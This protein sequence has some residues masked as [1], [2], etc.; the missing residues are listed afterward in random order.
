MS[1]FSS[2]E[3]YYSAGTSRE[4]LLE[5]YPDPYKAAVVQAILSGGSISKHLAAASKASLGAT[6]GVYLRYGESTFTNELPTGSS[7][8][9]ELN[10]AALLQVV[11]EATGGNPVTINFQ[12][13][14]IA[15]ERSFV[16]EYMQQRY[17]FN[18]ETGV[19]TRNPLGLVPLTDAPVLFVGIESLGEELR[20]E[21][22]YD[23]TSSYFEVIDDV[24]SGYAY[25][26]EYTIDSEV[27]GI[28]Q[29]KVEAAASITAITEEVSELR[30]DLLGVSFTT[31]DITTDAIFLSLI[32]DARDLGT[33]STSDFL[34]LYETINESRPF[35]DQASVGSAAEDGYYY[36][37]T[38]NNIDDATAAANDISGDI[39]QEYLWNY[40][41]EDG[42]YPTLAY[43]STFDTESRYL[44]IVPI[45][46]DGKFLSTTPE[47]PVYITGNNL[48]KKI[49]LSHTTFEEAIADNADIEDF[50]QVFY[51]FTV[52]MRATSGESVKYLYELWDREAVINGIK[53]DDSDTKLSTSETPNT[54]T[55][56]KSIKKVLT[57]HEH[58]YNTTITFTGINKENNPSGN[59]G[60]IGDVVSSISGDS[61]RLEKQ[62]TETSTEVVTVYGVS[63]KTLVTGRRNLNVNATFSNDEAFY[64]PINYDLVKALPSGAQSLILAESM[65]IIIYWL[66]REVVK[67]GFFQSTFFKV[68]LAVITIIIIVSTG[69]D[70]SAAFS[71]LLETTA[72]E[73][74]TEIAIYYATDYALSKLAEQGGIF[75]VIA[76]VYLAYTFEIG[77]FGDAAKAGNMPLAEQLM[78]AV[79]AISNTMLKASQ[80]EFEQIIDEGKQLLRSIEEDE[81]ELERATDLLETGGKYNP[82]Y[83]MNQRSHFDPNESPTAYFNRS[84]NTNPGIASLAYTAIYASVGV[85][86]PQFNGLRMI[87]VSPD[88][89]SF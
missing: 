52:D 18:V 45:R 81:E 72:V 65:S 69:F 54:S 24:G 17:G 50:R 15:N 38:Y 86:L 11:T 51:A 14:D 62:I 57:V 77:K 59:I 83:I 58:T 32:T 9:G 37:D 67:T 34:G 35:V 19:L 40:Y 87:E 21:Y 7:S 85:S 76:A 49:G 23:G 4:P 82:L 61:M 55:V 74:V 41:I 53:S 44:P 8:Y 29:T 63:G 1:W 25:H 88:T 26:V 10:E 80:L 27:A 3:S 73:L 2:S 71:T 16:G 31:D 70:A 56:G 66:H 79:T 43:E 89:L 78:K 28:A 22:S 42:T 60:A 12:D 48:L 39:A 84:L 13:L 33:I 64:I 46:Q 30:G 47:E 68:L 75:A 20:I 6:A 36:L 5:D